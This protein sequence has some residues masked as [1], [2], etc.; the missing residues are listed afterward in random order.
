MKMCKD[1]TGREK[2]CRSCDCDSAWKT[3]HY[4]EIKLLKL[5]NS[6]NFLGINTKTTVKSKLYSYSPVTAKNII[7]KDNP[8]NSML[9]LCLVA[10]SCPTLCDPWTVAC[11]APRSI[12]ILQARILEWVAKPSSRG[13]SQSRD[14]THIF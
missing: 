11:Q 1:W 7:L 3:Q 2:T 5:E 9:V 14:Q 10:Q 8:Y 13:S 4:L 12:G 6:R